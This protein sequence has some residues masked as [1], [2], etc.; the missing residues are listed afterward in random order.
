MTP[1]SFP[2]R[3]H[4][5]ETWY[6]TAQFVR[7][8]R[9][10]FQNRLN[11]VSRASK[12][13]PT[14]FCFSNFHTNKYLCGVRDPLEKLI[15]A[16]LVKTP[17][18]SSRFP[19]LVKVKETDL[20]SSTLFSS[21]KFNLILLSTFWFF[22]WSL[23]PGFSDQHLVRIYHNHHSRYMPCQSNLPSFYYKFPQ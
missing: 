13:M 7:P 16:Q 6:G 21:D 20:R 4:T 12:K 9:Y 1:V 18:P 15:V 10:A 14:A 23:P 2:T 11:G 8:E 3:T 22:K 17:Y 19:D 5:S